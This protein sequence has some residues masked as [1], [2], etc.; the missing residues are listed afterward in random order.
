MK[1]A[2]AIITAGL[3]SLATAAPG[4]AAG[5]VRATGHLLVP[6]SPLPGGSW[7]MSFD[8]DDNL[9]VGHISDRTIT[10]LDP[11]SGRVLATFGPVDG[12]EGSDDL[13]VGPD[14]AVYYTAI[15]TG[16]V[17]R[18]APDGTHSTV[19]NLG[20]GVNPITFTDDGRLFVGKAF[21]GDGLWEVPLNGDPVRLVDATPGVNG[22]DWYEG[23]LYA[24][25]PDL[26]EVIKVNVDEGVAWAPEVVLSGL[27]YPTAVDIA[28]DGTMYVADHDGGGIFRF[29]PVAH[30]KT[31]VA[32]STTV[33][34]MAID[35]RGRVFFSGG[36]D[37]AI[38]RIAGNGQVVVVSRPGIVGNSGIGAGIGADGKEWVYAPGKFEF[39]GFDGRTGRERLYESELPLPDTVFADGQ[40]LILSGTFA[41]AVAVW[42]PEAGSMLGFYPFF[43]VPTN[44]IR[45]D[46]DLIVAELGLGRVTRY[47]EG[48]ATSESWGDFVVPTGLAATGDD[49]YAADWATGIIFQ[50]VRDGVRLDPMV[51]AVTG[52]EGPEGL[53]ATADGDL[54]VVETWTKALTLIE[55]GPGSPVATTLL[56]GIDVGDPAPAGF[57]PYW[58]FDGVAVGPS[59][60][61][62]LSAGGIY[63]YELH[64]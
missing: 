23:Y 48:T 32:P 50:L 14:G 6:E 54:V 45:F 38:Y 16:E 1:R 5:P 20:M 22:F 60:A 17:G 61:I 43:A 56:T 52:L 21:I 11:N 8:R 36:N 57:W 9:W 42:N 37:G 26:G 53:A 30:S 62:Y 18:I 25:R 41:N 55:L 63:R 10:K 33:D 24:P 35:S 12:V 40:N 59:G 3:L 2:I 13:V 49:L 19:V 29:D 27:V 46:G 64:R 4:L 15:L 44:A 39:L 51:P 28:P 34:N 47:D 31:L 7:G 58:S